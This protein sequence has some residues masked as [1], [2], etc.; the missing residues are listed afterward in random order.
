M[1]ASRKPL[2]AAERTARILRDNSKSRFCTAFARDPAGIN[3][4]TRLDKDKT[5]ALKRASI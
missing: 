2:T 4:E 3:T 5:H 1:S